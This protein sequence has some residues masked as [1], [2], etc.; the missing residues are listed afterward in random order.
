MFTFVTMVGGNPQGDAYGFRYWSNPGAFAEHIDEGNMGRFQGF[1]GALWAASFCIVGPEYI[2]MVAG[3]AKRPRIYIKTAF[4]TVYWRFGIFFI[5]GALCVGVAIPYNDPTLV[6]IL[7]GEQEGAG[8][9]GASPYVI[10]MQNMA[11]PVLPHITNALLVTC[12]FSAGNAYTYCATRTLYAMAIEGRAP[13]VLRKCLP[14]GVPIYCFVAVMLFPLLSFLS[15]SNN[16]SKVLT[17]LLNLITA[18]G[19]IDFIVICITYLSFYYACKAQGFDRSTLPYYG[20]FQPYSA[21][22]S[23]TGL[24][25]VIFAYGYS[26][27][28]PGRWKI[29]DFFS[30]YTMVGVAPVLFI[31]WKVVKK[32]KFIPAHEVDLVWDAPII[33]AYE[34][35]FT[36]PPI[37]FWT[38][39][40][41]L[42][43]LKRDVPVDT[44]NV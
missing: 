4:K 28:L 26:V 9:G 33:D 21:W 1:L 5:V 18:G 37:G 44:R 41:Q 30:Y 19:L 15:V 40:L 16:S 14:N 23:L 38:E 24:V 32:T 25:M 8:T 7:S 34:E 29:D 42:V 12:I 13:K 10:A 35:T 22:I 39:V 36:S 27:F 17:W 6:A 43:G 20:R 2:S 11:I 31:F 3:E